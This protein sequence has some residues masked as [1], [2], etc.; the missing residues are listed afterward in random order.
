MTRSRDVADIDGL[1]TT[2][3]DIYAATAAATPSRIGVGANN[4]VLTADSAEATGMKWAAAAA[5]GG[6]TLLTTT[7][8]TASASISITGIDQ[9]YNQLV[10]VIS[11]AA[12]TS[13]SAYPSITFNSTGGTAYA[14]IFIR[15]PVTSVYSTVDQALIYWGMDAITQT[16]NTNNIGA[17]FTINRYADTTSAKTI[18]F[19]VTALNAAGVRQSLWG[20]MSFNNGGAAISSV[21]FA[22]TGNWTAQGNI[23]I[24]GVK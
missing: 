21:Q 4:T 8:F 15:T 24:Y 7:P 9:T 13:T 22:V 16:A 18:P 14:S 10:I 6:M 19:S 11:N 23:Y 17:V 3:G 12:T 20:T 5:S 1:L 2:K